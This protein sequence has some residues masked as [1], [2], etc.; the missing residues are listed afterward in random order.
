VDVTSWAGLEAEAPLIAERGRALLMR[1]GSGEGM[2]ASVAGDGLPRLHPV[3]VDI[4]DG[5]LVV[6][7]IDGSP[8]TRELLSDG[9]YAFHTHLDPA[10]PHELS[11][12]G[13]AH[14]VTDPHVHEGALATWPFDARDGY[15]LIEL[16]IEHALLGERETRDDWPPRYT[17]WHASA[18]SASG[19][20]PAGAAPGPATAAG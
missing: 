10:V 7:G 11:L 15:T 2:L 13:R 8:K 6:F 16:D 20:Q 4:V 5:H 18:G 19:F 17:A 1:T 12:R 14:V 3:V 9:R